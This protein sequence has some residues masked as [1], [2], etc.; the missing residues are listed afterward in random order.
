MYFNPSETKEEQP[1]DGRLTIVLLVFFLLLLLPFYHILI[2]KKQLFV[3]NYMQLDVRHDKQ[4]YLRQEEILTQHSE[5]L[6]LTYYPFFFLPLPINRADK[7]LLMTI[8]GVGPA[9]AETIVT[10]RQEFGPIL[11][12]VNLQEIRGIGR[13]RA[14]SL[15]NELVFD[16]AE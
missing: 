5:S 15:A 3:H 7:D 13:K 6:P 2:H 1:R 9:M 4:L 14:N 10:H 12:I 8:K 16:T 11:N